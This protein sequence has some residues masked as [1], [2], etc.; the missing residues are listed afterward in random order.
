MATYSLEEVMSGEGK[1]TYTLEEVV[2][3]KEPFGQRL[4]RE[5]ASVPRQLGLTARHG[6]QGYVGNTGDI[7]GAPIAALGN[8]AGLNLR[9]PS[10]IV[11]DLLD[12]S[13]L[14]KPE[15]KT[16]R[17]VAPGS[18]LLA[19]TGSMV[20]LAK[21]GVKAAA[22]PNV[23]AVVKQ[24]AAKPGLQASS[25]LGAGL[26]GGYTKETGGNA[27]AQFLAS[28]AGGIA[29]PMGVQGV[30]SM[31]NAAMNMLNRS[32]PNVTVVVERALNQS[33]FKMAD[34]PKNIVKDLEAD[35]AKAMQA[36]DLDPGA[37][38]RLV[39]YRM[40]GATPARGNLTLNPVD[41]TQQ[42]NLSKI[43]ANS[44]NPRLNALAMRQN[45][46]TGKL[47]E[48]LNTLG[49]NTADDQY[50]AGQRVIDALSTKQ[51][52]AKAGI[53]AAYN[54][55]RDASGRSVP[56]DRYA[57]SQTVNNLLD[58]A[59]VGGNLPGDVRNTINA[60]ATGKKSVGM[61]KTVDMPFTVEVA[62]QLKTQVGKLQ[63]ATTDGQTRM[64]LGLVR[65]AL[66]ETPIMQSR[67]V[68]PGNLPAVPGTV[69]PGNLQIGQSAI[70]AFN[71]ARGLNREWMQQVESTPALKAVVD[72]IEPDKFVQQYI[73][74][75][76][77]K[78]NVM[79]VAKLKAQIAGFPDAQ[80]AIRMQM[81]A[82]LKKAATGG[83]SDEA[84]VFSQ[85]GYNKALNAIG[86][87]KLGLFFSKDELAQM[88]AIG[89]VAEA[90]MIQPRGS[91][92]NNSNTGAMM[93]ATLIEK[94]ANNPITR[95]IPFGE[96]AIVKPGMEAANA[97]MA[98]PITN[99]PNALVVP[100]QKPLPNFP[101][102]LLMTPGLLTAE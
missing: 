96:A 36:G 22:N 87:R 31:K 66:D 35:V 5:I 71:K 33:G 64:A 7:L 47:I 85:S 48:G 11:R 38:E 28:L 37:M 34:V 27:G 68:N 8:M 43:G 102:P 63:R 77:T 14:P 93:L 94:L 55:A 73:I 25:A 40:V 101:L 90:E 83:A 95:K 78:S 91:A 84:R 53:D 80:Q 74:G 30:S 17:M 23:Q 51:A 76:G 39:A 19:G 24:L 1:K 70:D 99:V 61:H 13:G 98:R 9:Q 29:A 62:E 16:E 42:Q 92:V 67:Q 41:I 59:M 50:A 81:A 65:Q 44:S 56:L 57:F 2:G 20:S 15:T 89:K 79:D 4:N 45:E 26:A 69:P 60:I 58:D 12:R 46:N 49:A 10:V 54:A 72:G 32:Q 75:G 86:D 52:E 18:E 21:Q 6:I 88:R 82:Y 3:K 97:L 100:R